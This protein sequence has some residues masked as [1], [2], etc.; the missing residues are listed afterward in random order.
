MKRKWSFLAGVALS[1]GMLATVATAESGGNAQE[2]SQLKH[3]DLTDEQKEQL[4]A[5]REKHREALRALRDTM[6]VLHE[7]NREEFRESVMDILTDEQKAT[8]GPSA[9]DNEFDVVVYGERIEAVGES[10]RNIRTALGRWWDE[11][12]DPEYTER[13]YS[14]LNL[15]E[16]QKKT[17]RKLS[18]MQREARHRWSQRL[19]KAMDAILTDEQREELKKLKDEAF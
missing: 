18:E 1:L 15:T 19:H 6:A 2:H 17:L 14:K 3:L 13:V 12:N 11:M 5:L 16:E 8:L 9:L 10:V 4:Q 7:R